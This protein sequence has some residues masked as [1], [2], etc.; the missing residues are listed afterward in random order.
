MATAHPEE[1]KEKARTM[2]EEEGCTIT[3]TARRIGVAKNVVHGWAKARGWI[4]PEVVR[5]VR[6]QEQKLVVDPALDSLIKRMEALP[7]S[8]RE[9]DYSE[10][11]HQLACSIPLIL[12]QMSAQELVS[13]ADKVAKLVEVSRNILDLNGKQ[14]KAPSFNLGVLLSSSP[15]SAIPDRTP[16]LVDVERVEE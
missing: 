11:M 5:Q 8:A 7:R 9:A 13:K 4:V 16:Q 15:L 10:S 2:M 6:I 3:E 1:L 14:S 12:K